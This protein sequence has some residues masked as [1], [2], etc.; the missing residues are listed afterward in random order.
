MQPLIQV[1]EII[2]EAISQRS[3]VGDEGSTSQRQAKVVSWSA[4]RHVSF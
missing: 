3:R 2:A 1:P 4:M